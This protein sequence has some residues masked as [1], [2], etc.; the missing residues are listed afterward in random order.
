MHS[1][2]FIDIGYELTHEKAYRQI[3]VLCYNLKGRNAVAGLN[4]RPNR[5]CAFS[6]RKMNF[7]S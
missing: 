5:L 7:Q 6:L 2:V 1:A 4:N 3:S